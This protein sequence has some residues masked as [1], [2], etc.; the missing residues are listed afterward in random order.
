MATRPTAPVNGFAALTAAAPEDCTTPVEDCVVVP[1]DPEPELAADD[2]TELALALLAA[3]AL[4]LSLSLA[5][6]VATATLI[7]NH[8][9]PALY[10]TTYRS[11]HLSQ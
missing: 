10:I 5:V 8:P 1:A 7:S 4:A 9:H 2:L 3:L 6:G 11:R